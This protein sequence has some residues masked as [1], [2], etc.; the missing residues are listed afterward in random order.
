MMKAS[1]FRQFLLLTL[2]A[3]SCQNLERTKVS[4]TRKKDQVEGQGGKYGAAERH[5]SKIETT[6]S[7]T[8]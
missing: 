2:L 7:V 1:M 6:Q 5:I 8:L 4:Q 3:A